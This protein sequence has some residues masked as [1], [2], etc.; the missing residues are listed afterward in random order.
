MQYSEGNLIDGRYVLE[1]MIGSGGFGEVWLARDNQTDLEVAVKIYVAMDQQGLDDFRKEFQLS[2]NLNHTNLLHANYLGINTKDNRPFLV[3]P[4]CPRGSSTKRAGDMTER[5]IWKFLKDVSAGLAYLHAQ[6]PP[7]IHQDIKPDNILVLQ[8]GDFVVTDFGISKQLRLSMR[9]S[10]SSN[11]AGAVAYMGPERFNKNYQ[12]IK[13]SDIWSLGASAYELA[14]GDLPFSG[15]GGAF[16]KRGA[17]IPDLPGYSPELNNLI[18]GC[19]ASE[20]WDRPTA[21]QIN[22]YT[23][24]Y[25]NGGHP[26]VTWSA[27][28]VL[29]S[30]RSGTHRT[31][32]AAAPRK[33][34]PAWVY[35]LVAVAGIVVGGLIRIFLV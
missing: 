30:R 16:Q 13:A 5:E 21:Q 10:A 33:R 24:A 25:L 14:T 27:P 15:M 1:K 19:L 26:A 22:D 11:S 8:N 34:V 7:I 3:M 2:F 29:P 23:T 9:R 31:F 6:T 4:F 12:T 17:E 18:A 35:A 32:G 28:Q 20:T